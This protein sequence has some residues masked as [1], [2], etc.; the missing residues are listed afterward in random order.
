MAAFSFA[1][2]VM[3]PENARFSTISSSGLTL[4]AFMIGE[5]EYS[6]LLTEMDLTSPFPTP[7]VQ[8][9]FGI[10]IFVIPLVLLNLLIGL[11]VNVSVSF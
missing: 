10:F 11:A 6:D 4:M 1:F 2:K 3:L 9:F 5:I 7:A 8:I